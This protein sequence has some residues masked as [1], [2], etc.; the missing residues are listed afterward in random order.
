MSG[1]R[2]AP[3]PAEALALSS[4]AFQ[5]FPSPFT[6]RLARRTVMGSPGAFVRGEKRLRKMRLGNDPIFYHFKEAFVGFAESQ[7]KDHQFNPI[8]SFPWCC[9]AKIKIKPPL[10]NGQKA[11]PD[12]LTSRRRQWVHPG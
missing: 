10:F 2:A 7:K 9:V 8:T 3:C 4:G 12:N 5:P 11:K 1:Q 6:R